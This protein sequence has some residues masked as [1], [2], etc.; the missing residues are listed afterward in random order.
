MSTVWESEKVRNF[1]R[2]T[3]T[4]ST[5]LAMWPGWFGAKMTRLYKMNL[6]LLSGTWTNFPIL[7][8]RVYRSIILNH[9]LWMFLRFCRS[10]NSVRC[11]R[12]GAAHMAV[13]TAIYLLFSMANGVTAQLN[14]FWE[15]CNNSIMWVTDL[16]I[17]RMTISCSNASASLKFAMAS[18]NV[19]LSS[20]GVARVGSI[21]W[22]L[23]N[24]R[25]WARQTA[26]LWP[27]AS[28]PVPRKFSIDLIK[29]RH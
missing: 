17:L 15:K 16:S 3:S 10:I 5:T 1:C 26:P 2:I 9:F 18:S 21:Q 24:C 28:K 29:I 27:M 6:A 19:V 12:Q 7:I 25:S 20:A 11:R 8:G 23:T 14:T 13:F 22:P 4:I